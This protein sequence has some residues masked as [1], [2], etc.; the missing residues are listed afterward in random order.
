MMLTLLLSA[1]AFAQSDDEKKILA[2]IEDLKVEDAAARRRALEG[3]RDR[4]KAAAPLMLAVLADERPGL[5]GQID[6]LVVKLASADWKARDAAHKGLVRLG[7]HARARLQS[8]EAAPDAEVAWRVKA[9]LAEIEEKERD[10]ATYEYLRNAGLCEALGA[11]EEAKAAPLLA[12]LVDAAPT[13]NPA[14]ADAQFTMRAR[15]AEALGRLRASLSQEQADAAA[16]KTVELAQG[17]RDRRLG[18]PLLQTLGRLKSGVAVTPLLSYVK[19]AE[20]KDVHL[21]H[22]AMR[23]LAA[24]DDPRGVAGIVAQL[25]SDD[26]YLRY[27]AVEVLGEAG[28]DFGIDPR[29]APD[30]KAKAARAWWEKRYGK[31]WQD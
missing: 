1:L 17:T 9:A 2:L 14:L 12:R 28:A 6:D 7:R 13:A 26:V 23:A 27:G 24:I 16:E 20:R 21:K 4:G 3:L 5:E 18:V 8:H 30:D 25:A 10:E 22:A 15:A 29:S 31:D 19:D 11:L